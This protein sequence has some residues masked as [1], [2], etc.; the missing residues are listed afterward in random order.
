MLSKEQNDEERDATDDDSSNVAGLIK[1]IP[2][3]ARN[4]IIRYFQNDKSPRILLVTIC[5]ASSLRSS[6]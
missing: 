2:G 3:Q 5:F 6:Q 4:N 1:K